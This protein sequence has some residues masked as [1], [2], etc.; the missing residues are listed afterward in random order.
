MW[1]G[2]E[3]FPTHD[4]GLYSDHLRCVFTRIFNPS[5]PTDSVKNWTSRK[6]LQEIKVLLRCQEHLRKLVQLLWIHIVSSPALNFTS[7]LEDS[8]QRLSYL[9]NKVASHLFMRRLNSTWHGTCL[10]IWNK[11]MVSFCIIGALC[12]FP[13]VSK[14]PPHRLIQ[15]L[16]HWHGWSRA[17]KCRLVEYHG[18]SIR[19]SRAFHVWNPL[20]A[21]TF[22]PTMSYLTV[23]SLEAWNLMGKH[24]TWEAKSVGRKKHGTQKIKTQW[25]WMSWMLRPKVE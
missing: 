6:V 8:F 5:F 18:K 23:S 19:S 15:K 1:P 11:W 12:R 13:K 16:G 20:A 21:V 25:P 24:L 10:N 4:L 2:S 17:A 3:A 7:N 14:K 9:A 22:N